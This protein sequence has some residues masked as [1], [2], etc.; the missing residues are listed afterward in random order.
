MERKLICNPHIASIEITFGPQNYGQTP[1]TVRQ[2]RRHDRELPCF[3]LKSFKRKPPNAPRRIRFGGEGGCRPRKGG[4]GP[5]AP[6]RARASVSRS[7]ERDTY[8]H[9][10]AASRWKRQLKAR[11]HM[12]PRDESASAVHLLE[13]FT[14]TTSEQLADLLQSSN[15][16][17]STIMPSAYVY[18]P[19]VGF[20]P[21]PTYELIMLMGS[22]SKGR[23]SLRTDSSVVWCVAIGTCCNAVLGTTNKNSF[24]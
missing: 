14:H 22:F 13:R 21:G 15:R 5:K 12:A 18:C 8:V 24:I 23:D 2:W 11:R 16:P 3:Q 17:G 6:P 9:V 7:A 10:A 4:G 19:P 20:S 1:P